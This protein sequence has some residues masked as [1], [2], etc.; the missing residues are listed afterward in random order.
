VE[1]LLKHAVEAQLIEWVPATMLSLPGSGTMTLPG[2]RWVDC[3]QFLHAFLLCEWSLASGSG[4]DLTVTLE[5]APSAASSTT[6]WV[7][8]ASGTMSASAVVIDGRFGATNP[9]M[10]VLRLKYSAANA[11]SGTL[12]VVLLLKET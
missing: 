12:R 5:T 11:V 3:A 7:T 9:P 6:S 10:G 2:D 1:L 4:S 8:V